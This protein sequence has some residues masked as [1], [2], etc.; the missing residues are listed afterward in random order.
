M[1][2]GYTTLKSH[3]SVIESNKE[4]VQEMSKPMSREEMEARV[5]AIDAAMLLPANTEGAR[6][7]LNNLGGQISE[8]EWFKA[9]TITAWCEPPEEEQRPPWFVPTPAPRTKLYTPRLLPAPVRILDGVRIPA[10]EAGAEWLVGLLCEFTNY[11]NWL[12]AATVHT[13]VGKALGQVSEREL[14]SWFIIGIETP[15]HAHALFT[16]WHKAI[17][18]KK[19]VPLS[20]GDLFVCPEMAYPYSIQRIPKKP[21]TAKQ[22]RAKFAWEVAQYRPPKE[23]QPQPGSSGPVP[24]VVY[25]M[26]SGCYRDDGTHS[27]LC[28][29]HVPKENG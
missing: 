10:T 15:G 21:L 3:Y 29:R 4:T 19:A 28:P 27:M 5:A 11:S 2:P 18:A 6:D 9:A 24:P 12:R 22:R 8:A 20:P 25:P 16:A 17:M 1:D 14:A 23:P 26:C 13:F 7:L